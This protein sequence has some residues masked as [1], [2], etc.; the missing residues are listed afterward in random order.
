MHLGSLSWPA[1][2]GSVTAMGSLGY[3]SNG[4]SSDHHQI[5]WTHTHPTWTPSSSS[6]F[7]WQ[8]PAPPKECTTSKYCIQILLVHDRVDSLQ[9][10]HGVKMEF[11]FI[12]ISIILNIHLELEQNRAATHE[13]YCV[14]YWYT[15][16]LLKIYCKLL[17]LKL[18]LW[19]PL[20]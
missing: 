1:W 9:C 19:Y 10:S 3:I 15:S 12:W 2:Q 7:S 6:L 4:W 5:L 20:S 13:A 17:V 18:K 16:S 14:T 8:W 11:I